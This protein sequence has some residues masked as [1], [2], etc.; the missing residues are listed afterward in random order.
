MDK[1]ELRRHMKES[2]LLAAYLTSTHNTDDIVARFAAEAVHKCDHTT[3]PQHETH[4][5]GACAHCIAEAMSA[6]LTDPAP[7]RAVAAAEEE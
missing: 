1:T 7:P 6:L 3:A 5:F 2:R 4:D